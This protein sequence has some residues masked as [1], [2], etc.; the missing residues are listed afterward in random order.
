MKAKRTAKFYNGLAQERGPHRALEVAIADVLELQAAI[1][2]AK[3][4]ASSPEQLVITGLRRMIVE[5]TRP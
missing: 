2:T 4:P 3:L 5:E 1:D